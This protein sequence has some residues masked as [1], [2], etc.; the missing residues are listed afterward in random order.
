MVTADDAEQ[1]GWDA[2]GCEVTRHIGGPAGHEALAFEVHHWNWGFG[3]NAGDIAPN[4]LVEHDVANYKEARLPGARHQLLD[5]A[6]GNG[7]GCPMGFWGA[8]VQETRERA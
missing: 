5:P 7:G 1:F 3:R 6:C 4:E 2:Q 8:F